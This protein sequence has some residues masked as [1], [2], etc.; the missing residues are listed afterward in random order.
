M[1][2]KAL[3]HDS[4][5][6]AAFNITLRDVVILSEMPDTSSRSLGR[7]GLQTLLPSSRARIIV[8]V[9][10]SIY[11]DQWAFQSAR[12]GITATETKENQVSNLDVR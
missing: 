6:A 2:R 12:T 5:Q 8:S 4:L 11:D 3:S 1:E 7:K 10:R 9:F